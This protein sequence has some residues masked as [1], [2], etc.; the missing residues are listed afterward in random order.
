MRRC[1]FNYARAVR[2]RPKCETEMH[3]TDQGQAA[4]Y[5]RMALPLMAKYRVPV[6]PPNY[7]VWYDYVSGTNGAL[8]GRLD[9]LMSAQDTLRPEQLEMLYRDYVA[10][11]EFK[12]ANHARELLQ[13]LL[14]GASDSFGDAN[15]EFAQFDDALDTIAGGLSE[16]ST[17]DEVRNALRELS[18]ETKR[19]RA[20]AA[21]LAERV[22]QSQRDV[23]ALRAELEQGKRPSSLD[24]LTGLSSRGAFDKRIESLARR[25]DESGKDFGLLMIDIDRF[26]LI[27]DTH[28]NL[29]GDKVIRF[30]ANTITEMVKGKDLV[31]RYG[32]ET[33]AVLLPDA[34]SQGCGAVAES[35]RADIEKARLVK[36]STKAP[37][38]VVTVSCGAAAFRPGDTPGSLVGRADAA[39]Y[40]AK[41]RGRNRTTDESMVDSRELREA[42]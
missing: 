1:S 30:I 15:E 5:L 28:G 31:A 34:N 42:G 33:F 32:G 26:R 9:R 21:K 37:L 6:T 36:S 11:F 7:A 14:R 20:H 41:Q 38:G 40:H 24:S 27:N 19:V 10:T 22:A 13:R 8:A 4:E 3:E 18:T 25:Y 12:F 17:G 35:I 16:E 29:V 2:A 39:L 23:E